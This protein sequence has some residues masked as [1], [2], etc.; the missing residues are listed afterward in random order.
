MEEILAS[1]RRIIS[2]DG[3]TMEAAPPPDDSVLDLT[4]ML[5]NEPPT[6]AAPAA[7]PAPAPTPSAAPEVAMELAMEDHAPEAPPAAPPPPPSAPASPASSEESL[8]S[9]VTAQAAAQAISSNIS[10]PHAQIDPLPM[11]AGHRTLESMVLDQ[12]KPILKEWLD[13]NLPTMVERI[14]QKE[15]R[16]ITRDVG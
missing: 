9:N 11:G 15:I 2:E 13:K 12:L 1:I 10:R 8:I 4:Q 16:K 6:P 5:E 14:V 3:G 7:T